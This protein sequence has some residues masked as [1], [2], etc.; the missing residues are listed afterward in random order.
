M[1]EFR[2]HVA[3]VEAAGGRVAFIG[4]GWPA[5]AQA[6][7]EE[8]RLPNALFLCDSERHAYQMLGMNRGLLTFLSPRAGWR[9]LQALA[10]GHCQTRTQGDNTQQG[11]AAVVQPDGTLGYCY[12]SR[13]AGDHPSVTEVMAAF[14][15]S[16][17]S[18]VS[19]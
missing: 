10:R 18:P 7:R 3:E 8:M 16:L 17:S 1:A 12:R 2:P 13:F 4:S 11:G 9:Y 19:R 5:A 6:F 14:Q 15:S